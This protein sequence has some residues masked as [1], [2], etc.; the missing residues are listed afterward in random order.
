MFSLAAFDALFQAERD[1]EGAAEWRGMYWGD[2]HRFTNFQARRREVLGLKSALQKSK[3]RPASQ[4]DCKPCVILFLL[5]LLLLLLLC[6]CVW[7]GEAS[8]VLGPVS[9]LSRC[10]T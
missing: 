4:I 2:R 1:A 7:G 8:F 10:P 6:V 9:T 5:L 3:Y